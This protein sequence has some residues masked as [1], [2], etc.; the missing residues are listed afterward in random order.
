MVLIIIRLLSEQ[1]NLGP[2]RGL[3]CPTFKLDLHGK[4]ASFI[5]VKCQS[6]ISI[7]DIRLQ[8]HWEGKTIINITAFHFYNEF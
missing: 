8:V 2:G 5:T 3:G 6:A 4:I 1:Q 7:M